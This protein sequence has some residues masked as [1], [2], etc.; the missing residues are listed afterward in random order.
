L[1]IPFTFAGVLAILICT[2]AIAR[3]GRNSASFAL[4]N[5]SKSH[6]NSQSLYSR[7]LLASTSAAAVSNHR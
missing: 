2:L 5:F 4:G 6:M 7:L 1:T 3:E